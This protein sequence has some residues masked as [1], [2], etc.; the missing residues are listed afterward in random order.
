MNHRKGNCFLVNPSLPHC[1][2]RQVD[3]YTEFSQEDCYEDIEKVQ[4][5][6]QRGHKSRQNFNLKIMGY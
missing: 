5:D 3:F 1:I 2:V 6:P 4:N